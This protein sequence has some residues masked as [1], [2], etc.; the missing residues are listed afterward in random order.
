MAERLTKFKHNGEI[1]NKNNHYV[2]TTI[3][4]RN[5]F[6]LQQY[7]FIEEYFTRL[8]G[9]VENSE[10]NQI[11]LDRNAHEVSKIHEIL[12]DKFFN[13]INSKFMLEHWKDATIESGRI[14]KTN[15][16]FYKAL[17]G[18]LKASEEYF[19]GVVWFMGGY[20]MF[21]NLA[22]LLNRVYVVR[23]NC[24]FGEIC[25]DMLD[26]DGMFDD[27]TF[28]RYGLNHKIVSE[29]EKSREWVKIMSK[30]AEPKTEVFSE[31][32]TITTKNNDVRAE[33][34]NIPTFHDYQFEEYVLTTEFKVSERNKKLGE[35]LKAARL[36]AEEQSLEQV[37]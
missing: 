16:R 4:D 15:Q 14:P 34:A 12:H 33:Q 8:H 6:C 29:S 10:T 26:V 21:Q 17:T 19:K 27:S 5:G 20:N 7:P 23:L 11:V 24:D 2:F 31:Y 22:P 13:I 30:P 3:I 32:M 18:M 37:S 9:F 36:E 35:E 28:Q 25:P 1:Y